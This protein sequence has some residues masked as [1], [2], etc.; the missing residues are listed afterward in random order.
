MVT[1]ELP[2]Q[3][4]IKPEIIFLTSSLEGSGKSMRVIS[5]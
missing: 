3:E 2:F 1:F 5:F 4:L